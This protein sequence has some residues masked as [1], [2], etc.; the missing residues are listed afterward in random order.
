MISTSTS[1]T[2]GHTGNRSTGPGHAGVPEHCLA[3]TAEGSVCVLQGCAG[4][5]AEGTLV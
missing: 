3:Q 5:Q 1:H 4:R 2:W